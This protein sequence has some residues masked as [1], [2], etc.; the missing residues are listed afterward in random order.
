MIRLIRIDV[1]QF[2]K[3]RFHNLATRAKFL[4]I[5]EMKISLVKY[6]LHKRIFTLK[7]SLFQTILI[8]FSVRNKHAIKKK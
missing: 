8:F 2:Y 5:A 3:C 1:V 4:G 6:N 7:L